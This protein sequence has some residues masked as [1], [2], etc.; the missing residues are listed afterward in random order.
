MIRTIV[1][2]MI[3]AALG[4]LAIAAWGAWDGFH[5][6][7]PHRRDLAPGWETAVISALWYALFL[8][9]MGVVAG[10]LIGG[11]AGL[12]SALVRATSSSA[13]SPR[14]APSA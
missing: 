14:P 12:G 11:G 3:G 10:G 1:G 9:W 13:P 7:V 8:G 2:G 5:D 4:V 6:G